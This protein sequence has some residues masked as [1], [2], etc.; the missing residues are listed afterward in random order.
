MQTIVDD[1][2]PLVMFV[3]GV[4]LALLIRRVELPRV[5]GRFA[6]AIVALL[7]TFTGVFFVAYIAWSALGGPSR[8]EYFFPESP[9]LG[10]VYL[11]LMGLIPLLVIR[12]ALLAR[13]EQPRRQRNRIE[14][15]SSTSESA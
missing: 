7:G 4:A 6:Y 5:S 11:I 14:I 8:D 15:V 3:F 13:R 2:V 12:S 1:C 9:W 10:V